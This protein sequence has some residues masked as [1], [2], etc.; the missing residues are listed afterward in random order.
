LQARG[1]AP[2]PIDVSEPAG[3]GSDHPLAAETP[4]KRR[5]P[6]AQISDV[7]RVSYTR[8]VHEPEPQKPNAPWLRRALSSCVFS[9]LMVSSGACNPVSE[10]VFKQPRLVILYTSCTVNRTYTAAYDPT[11]SFTPNLKAFAERAAVFEKHHTESGQSGIAFASLFSGSQAPVHG[12]FK[13]PRKLQPQLVVVPEIFTAGGY[14]A[15]S[16]LVQKMASSRLG[17]GQGVEPAQQYLDGPLV[18]E[19]LPFKAI[20]QRLKT[21]PDYR[22]FV[23]T[24]FTVTHAPYQGTLLDEFCEE[25]PVECSQR[26][27]DDELAQHKRLSKDFHREISVNFDAAVEDLGFSDKDIERYTALNEL[28]YK[29]DM[30]R[31]DKMF[32]GVVRAVQEAGL[33]DDALI[34]FS[35]D[36]GEVLRRDNAFFFWTHG[37]Q[38]APEVINIPLLMS[39]PNAGIPAGRYDGVSRSI[40]VM[41]TLAGL[42]G[43]PLPEDYVGRGEDLSRPLRGLSRA[44][45]LIAFSHSALLYAPLRAARM[46][47]M[48]S[49]FPAPDP[50]FMWVSARKGD[51]YYKLRRRADDTWYRSVYDITHDPEE[52][53]DLF[54]PADVEQ[55]KTLELLDQYKEET[56]EAAYTTQ[57]GSLPRDEAIRMLRS[58][59]YID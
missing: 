13:H 49:L 36:H 33:F 35:A 42:A 32:G 26:G 17:Y 1:P 52:R 43:L 4:R 27:S 16:W 9:L 57:A 25:Y 38:L 11:V 55:R 24:N 15:H 45:D 28:L 46:P 44:P 3:A 51:F 23:V 59:G 53:H 14:D 29:S 21:D 10:P 8:R 6:A 58:M 56:R 20:V 31:L 47:L 18:A 2:D 5:R 34:V 40:D 7:V 41:P 19:S 50:E 30:Y 48:S 37:Y 54:D 39:G 22:A 12:V